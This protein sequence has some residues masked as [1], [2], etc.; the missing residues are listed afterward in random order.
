MRVALATLALTLPCVGAAQEPVFV[1]PPVTM[2]Q[3]GGLVGADVEA[4]GGTV[5][6]SSELA[7]GVLAPWTVALHAVGIDARG[8]GA[9]LARLHI[10]TRV[11][12]FKLDRPRQ[13]LIVSVYGAASVPLGDERDAVA[14][15]HGIPEA[16][17]GVSAT[18]MARRG[19]AFVNLSLARIPTPAGDLTAGT[20]GL[21]AGWRPRPG[22]YGDLE[23][24]LFAEALGRYVERGAVSI[25]LAPGLLVHSRNKVLKLGV[26]IPV[27]TREE[28]R[29]ATVRV[30]LKLLL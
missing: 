25:G 23:A 1:T 11:R 14:E 21:A 4:R 28:D 13:W 15:T 2:Y 30:S 24:Q 29:E 26:L 7:F 3:L 8:A 19:D 22:R 16:T 10:G 18:R 5:A 6:L 20:F 9:E 17:L 27:A 12:L